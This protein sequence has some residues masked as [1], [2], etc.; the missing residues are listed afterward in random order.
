LIELRFRRA[1]RANSLFQSVEK[2]KV[3]G[4]AIALNPRA[5]FAS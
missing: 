5:P 4:A 1:P 2:A 3:N